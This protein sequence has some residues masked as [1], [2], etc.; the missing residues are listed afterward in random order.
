VT[1]VPAATVM[2]AG[3]KLKLSIFTSTPTAGACC[4]LATEPLPAANSRIAAAT[5]GTAN[6]AMHTRI[7]MTFFLSE[8]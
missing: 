5:T 3:P 7:L 1:V 8:F 2:A 6:L 4:A